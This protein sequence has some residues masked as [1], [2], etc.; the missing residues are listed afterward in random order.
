MGR[1]VQGITR[2]GFIVGTWAGALSLVMCLLAVVSKEQGFSVVLVC[3]YLQ[4][5][6]WSNVVPWVLRPLFGMS[7]SKTVAKSTSTTTFITLYRLGLLVVGSTLIALWRLS[8]NNGPVTVFTA[9]DNG[10]A[11]AEHL[12]ERLMTYAYYHWLQVVPLVWPS[13][14]IHDL[15]FGTLKVRC[16]LGCMYRTAMACI[17]Q[18]GGL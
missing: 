3:A 5:T 8:L 10:A 15:S 2:G 9:A 6:V 14:L 1:D 12:S 4:T 13:R 18:W 11:F 7:S 17:P 16:V